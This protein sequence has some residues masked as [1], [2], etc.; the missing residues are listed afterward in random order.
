M[1][2]VIETSAEE[3]N[4]SDILQQ[5]L[6]TYKFESEQTIYQEQKDNE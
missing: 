3:G 1:H 6:E 4:F 5:L 2:S